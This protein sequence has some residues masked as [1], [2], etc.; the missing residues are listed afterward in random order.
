M[1]KVALCF[2]GQPRFVENLSVPESYAKFFRRPEYNLESYGHCWWQ[3]DH[4]YKSTSWTQDHADYAAQDDTINRL[5]DYYSFDRF[6]IEQ[7]KNFRFI[8]EEFR[9]AYKKVVHKIN[10]T[11]LR[12]NN[13]LSQLYSNELVAKLVPDTYDFY[14]L[15][16]YDTTLTDVPDLTQLDPERLYLS[17]CN[18]FADVLY[19][20]G[21]KFLPWP[22]VMYT[23]AQQKILPIDGFM[24][25]EFKKFAFLE[26]G[27]NMSQLTYLPMFGHISR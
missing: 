11:E 24:P 6:M 9:E 12:E 7:P 13:T 27:F 14:V 17:N 4:V 15:C 20:F 21:K 22:R 1:I 10:Y 3:K 2:Y 19:I 23:L 16:R 26:A 25:E 18:T 8:H 5:Y